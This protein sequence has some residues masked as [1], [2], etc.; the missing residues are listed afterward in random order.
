MIKLKDI[1][2]E[3]VNEGVRDPGI[4]KC[5]FAAGGTG[6]GKSK[7]LSDIFG[8]AKGSTLSATGL[9]LIN[10]DTAFE[11]SLKSKGID[12]DLS[13][14]SPDEF[15]SVASDDPN[16]IRSKSK[17]VQ[18]K[19]L[20]QYIEGRLGVIID[21]TG[22][23]YQKI[24]DKKEFFESIGYDCMMVFV[25]TSYDVALARNMRRDRKIPE[26]IV[27]QL[28]QNAQNNMGKFQQLFGKNFIIVDNSGDFYI[29]KSVKKA[30][31]KFI[32]EPTKNRKG[33]EWKANQI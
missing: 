22:E 4:L 26:D 21:G 31:D 9:K 8:I 32:R 16:S 10:N 25:N 6:S 5:V 29:D 23:D 1:L 17:V 3:N 24:K 27:K 20:R 19:I 2:F 11:K 18:N 28:W 15:K 14:L 30:V 7:V 33:I 12:L 13:K